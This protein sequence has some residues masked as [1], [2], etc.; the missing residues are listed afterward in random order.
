[1][2]APEDVEEAQAFAVKTVMD[3]NDQANSFSIEGGKIY[4]FA[5]AGDARS[6]SAMTKGDRMDKP[7]PA[8]SQEV[9][10]LYMT[11]E[12]F[13]DKVKKH[14]WSYEYSSGNTYY[15]GQ[16]SS[17]DLRRAYQDFKDR[18]WD[19]PG[20][21]DLRLWSYGNIIED[22]QQDDDGNLYRS[23]SPQRRAYVISKD[24]TISREDWDKIDRWFNK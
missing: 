18:G 23:G 9:G 13:R 12:E 6:W 22:L 11:R 5:S 10:D 8:S 17:E 20:W 15:K 19:P 14:N 3:P 24:A 7:A 1:M 16:E 21:E 4:F 2:D